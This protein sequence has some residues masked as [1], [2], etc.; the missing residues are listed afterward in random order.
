MRFAPMLRSSP[1]ARWPRA[2]AR[3]RRRA[4]G[5]ASADTVSIKGFAFGPANL[6]VGTGTTVTWTN[7]DPTTHTTTADTSDAQ[8]WDSGN[9]SANTS[10]AVTFTKPGTYSYH[11]EIHNYMTGT[12]IV[13]GVTGR[14]GGLLDELAPAVRL[15]L[16]AV[17]LGRRLDALPRLGRARRR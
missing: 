4:A 14:R 17:L 10:Y 2:A 11:C 7:T 8:P 13:G 9:L 15:D 3:P 6:H 1:P 16:D 5:S 12:I